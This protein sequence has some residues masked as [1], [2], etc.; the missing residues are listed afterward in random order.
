MPPAQTA[1]AGQTP[2]PAVN[3]AQPP[4]REELVAWLRQ[5]APVAMAELTKHFKKRLKSQGDRDAF[6]KTFK[7]IARH[8]EI[9]KGSG[10][11]LVV[12]RNP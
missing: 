2:T 1:T 6:A 10:I 11:K 12:L 4:T 9:P 7:D 8:Q 5:T 3:V